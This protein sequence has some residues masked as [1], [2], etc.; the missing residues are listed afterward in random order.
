MPGLPVSKR[1]GVKMHESLTNR[2]PLC[3]QI[4]ELP[5]ISCRSPCGGVDNEMGKDEAS[6]TCEIGSGY[7]GRLHNPWREGILLGR[8]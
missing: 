8:F 5:C 2:T 6:C 4:P 3:Q 1:E 7:R